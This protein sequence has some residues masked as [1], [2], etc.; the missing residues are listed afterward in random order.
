MHL[1]M[2]VNHNTFSTSIDATKAV[3]S[4][5]H[6]IFAAPYSFVMRRLKKP[7]Q[8]G[9][10]ASI[11][12]ILLG[13]TIHSTLVA[14]GIL[15][16]LLIC[17]FPH[18]LKSYQCHIALSTNETCRNPK[19]FALFLFDTNG[20]T[21]IIDNAANTLVCNDKSL[22]VGKIQDAGVHLD[23]ATGSTGPQLW[24]GNIGLSCDNN[25]SISHTYE[26]ENVVYNPKSPFNILSIGQ[27]GMHFGKS[28]LPPTSDDDGTW[29]KSSANSTCFAWDH[30]QFSQTFAHSANGLPE[31]PVNTGTCSFYSYCT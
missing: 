22:F 12:S 31:L 7:P 15:R 29:A 3:Y 6:T 16:I 18:C 20:L 21:F 2:D 9:Y 10:L 23:T 14:I 28:D 26:F 5:F 27:V 8:N 11:A 13:Y 19:G 25:N 24:I 1:H 17:Y 4:I 30:G